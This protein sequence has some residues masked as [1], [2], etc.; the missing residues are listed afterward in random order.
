MC[1]EMEKAI[2]RECV[3][4]HVRLLLK[5]KILP[6]ALGFVQILYRP[7]LFLII[8]SDC[9]RDPCYH[10]SPGKDEIPHWTLK[11]ANTAKAE[12][13]LPGHDHLDIY[14]VRMTLDDYKEALKEKVTQYGYG[15]L[16]QKNRFQHIE[17]VIGN[18]KTIWKI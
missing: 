9:F 4:E 5:N 6:E 1:Q 7:I 11:F 14:H 2:A 8:S 10:R 13:E 12:I 16:D 3:I 18:L 15:I 17:T